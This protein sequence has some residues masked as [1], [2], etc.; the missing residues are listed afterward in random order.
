KQDGQKKSR[1]A[2]SN[3][4]VPTTRSNTCF[5]YKRRILGN[6]QKSF[7]RLVRTPSFRF[8]KEHFDV[9]PSQIMLRQSSHIAINDFTVFIALNTNMIKL[10]LNQPAEFTI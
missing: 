8:T 9:M 6:F 1:K 4:T 5:R 10:M 7:Y 2:L 3:Y